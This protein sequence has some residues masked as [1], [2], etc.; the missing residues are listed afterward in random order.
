MLRLT[1][2][3]SSCSHVIQLHSVCKQQNTQL[4]ERTIGRVR[5]NGK[6]WWF[7]QEIECNT[8]TLR[9]WEK[10]MDV[11]VHVCVCVDSI[12]IFTQP[13]MDPLKRCSYNTPPPAMNCRSIFQGCIYLQGQA[14]CWSLFCAF[15]CTCVRVNL[16]L[17]MRIH[18]SGGVSLCVCALVKEGTVT[19]FVYSLLHAGLGLY[20]WN[21]STL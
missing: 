15:E 13:E 10:K 18:V 17:G 21:T 2:D 1:R 6:K 12:S 9:A 7:V 11:C 16:L 5:E 8:V 20:L 4:Q 19:V 14:S 3:W